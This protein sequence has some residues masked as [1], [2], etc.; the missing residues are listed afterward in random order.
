MRTVDGNLDYTLNQTLCKAAAC[1][2]QNFQQFAGAAH[3]QIEMTRQT[4]TKCRGEL[5]QRGRSEG[6]TWTEVLNAAI[7][8][9]AESL[10]SSLRAK[11]NAE[12][13]LCCPKMLQLFPLLL[14]LLLFDILGWLD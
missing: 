13:V 4:A 14:L 7:C 1:R 10:L 9:A 11:P 6:D 8:F 12:G 2:P 5:R 3:A